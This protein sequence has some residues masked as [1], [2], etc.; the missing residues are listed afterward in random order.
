VFHIQP[1]LNPIL[2]VDW[3]LGR[4]AGAPSGEV[5][6]KGDVISDEETGAEILFFKFC[7][8]GTFN[9]NEEA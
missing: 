9:L 7:E 5:F 6:R 8:A 4:T 2:Q 1:A 3:V